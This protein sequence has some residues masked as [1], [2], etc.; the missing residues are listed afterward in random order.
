MT[1]PGLT[2]INRPRTARRS[3]GGS[4]AS[5]RSNLINEVRFGYQKLD[6]TTSAADAS[7]EEIPSIEITELG[8][9]GF[10][11]ANSRTAIGLAV[12]LP[13]Y[14]INNTYQFINTLSYLKGRHAFK[15]GV[16]VRLIDVESFFVPTIRGRLRLPD[17]AALRRRRRRDGQHQQAAAGRPGDPVL[18]LERLLRVRAGRMA[19]EGQPHAEPRPAVRDA[20]QLDREP[21]PVNDDHRGGGRRR[22]AVRASCR[23][24]KRDTNNWQPRVGFNWNPRTEAGGILGVLTGGD[25][26]VVRGGYAR[27]ND[28]AFININLNIASALPFVAAIN[29]P[30]LAN[31]FRVLPGAACSP[32][33][34]P[35]P[36]GADDRVGGLRVAGRRP[37]QLRDAA[38]ADAATSC[39][40]SATSA[41]R[42]ATSSRRS[43]ATRG[44]RSRTVRASIRPSASSASAPTPPSPATT[45]CRPA[46]TSACRGGFSAG[47][48]YTWSKFIDT[49][50]EIFNPSSG[51]VAVAQDS[52]DL[53]AD[54]AVS[55]YDRPHRL[56]G[57]FVYELPFYRTERRR[58]QAPRRLADERRSSRSRAARRSPC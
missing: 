35:E 44:C 19:R 10:N 50:S 31:A 26:L 14:R 38:R 58:R 6:T 47:V 3:P 29:N 55:T 17:A 23:G 32:A 52:F 12:N 36:A 39:C 37:V 9:T 20:G 56:T 27:T 46:S 13:Q 40:A 24:P 7:S 42:A 8:L 51:E 25:K 28:Y 45:R 49:A 2:T 5:S 1:P 4:R 53:D 54:R 34:N 41:R 30:N 48:H 33:V 18:R 43:T 11:A 21:D 15:G 16:D 57:N 22:R